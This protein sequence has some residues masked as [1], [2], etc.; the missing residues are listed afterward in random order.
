MFFGVTGTPPNCELCVEECYN[1]WNGY[2]STETGR[3]A[4]LMVNTSALLARFG[5]MSYSQ[6]N[7][8]IQIL[9]NNLTYAST[10]FEGAQYDTRA[11][12]AQFRQVSQCS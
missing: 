1:N 2:I 10:V 5:S 4:N 6:I 3:L 7:T 8:E 9:N 12:E 11:K